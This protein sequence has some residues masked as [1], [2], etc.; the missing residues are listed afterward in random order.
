MMKEHFLQSQEWEKYEQMEGHQ[1]F[2]LEG[3]GFR[4]MAILK[5][6]PMGNYL[7]C[8][9]GPAVETKEG[10]KRALDSLVK[11]AKEQKAF[12]VR[13]EPTLVLGETDGDVNV[14][15][16]KKMGFKK[17]HDLDPAH[18]WVLD[19]TQNMDE[20]M[21]GI[22]KQKVRQWRIRE[23]H[24]VEIIKTQDPEKIGMLSGLLEKLGDSRHF[25]PQNENHLKN[26]LKAG[27]ATLYAAMKDGNVVAS[28]LVHDYDGVRFSMHGAINDEYKA[29]R[30]GGI[31]HVQAIIDAK[32]AGFSEYDFW[33][34]TPSEDKSHPWHG[35]TQY[36]KSFGGRQV[37]YCG[38]WDLPVKKMRYGVYE[39][40]RGMKRGL[41]H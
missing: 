14:D 25:T 23:K 10:L 21:A 30:A 20:I 4:A 17:T 34:M 16:L 28:Q 24:G 5:E 35:F 32:E 37:D 7:F 6:T 22:E 38:T 2:R 1:T 33:G 41:R 27:F 18:T 19:L 11:L 36:K 3:E 15:E 31:L 29:L 40:V 39:V 8:P 9:Y 26:Q 13:V 12:F